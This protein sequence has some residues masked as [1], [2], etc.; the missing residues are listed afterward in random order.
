MPFSLRCRRRKFCA[1]FDTQK[2]T[3]ELKTGSPNG[4]HWAPFLSVF[5]CDIRCRVYISPGVWAPIFCKGTYPSIPPLIMLQRAIKSLQRLSTVATVLLMNFWFCK[6]ANL[7]NQK[8]FSC[9]DNGISALKVSRCFYCLNCPKFGLATRFQI[10]S[11]EC[12][13]FDFS[14]GTDTANKY[15]SSGLKNSK[16]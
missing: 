1:N 14:W 16:L 13:K 9:A 6:L 12:T 5:R 7:R 10:F 2:S 11:A 3:K 8:S 4:C 15:K